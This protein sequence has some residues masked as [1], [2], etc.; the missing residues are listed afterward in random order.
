MASLDWEKANRK[1]SVST[2]FY[3]SP[4]RKTGFKPATKKLM[5]SKYDGTCYSCGKTF[6]K[7][8]KIVYEFFLS[9]ARHPNCKRKID[10]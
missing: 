7:G 2:G 3:S 5:A 4:S 6:K 1:Q 9:K 10:N 8:N